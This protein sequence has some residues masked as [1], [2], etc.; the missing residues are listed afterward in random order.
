MKTHLWLSLGVVA[1][2]AACSDGTNTSI[3]QENASPDKDATAPSAPDIATRQF[4]TWLDT[5]FE[6][7]LNFSPQTRTRLGDKTDYDQLDDAS[8]AAERKELEWRRASVAEMKQKFSRDSL[9]AT[10][11]TSWDLWEFLLAQE[12]AGVPYR[13]HRYIFGRRGPHTWL[14][15][16]LI[17]HHKVDT[18]ADLDAY[19][20]RLKQVD[21]Q[22]GQ[23]LDRAKTS[24][25]QG[26][27][28]PYFD[29]ELALSQSQ[30]VIDGEPF[31]DGE[32]TALWL[33]INSKIDSLVAAGQM[34]ETGADEYRT[35]FSTAMLEDVESAY[36]SVIAWLSSDKGKV[37]DEAQGAWALPDGEA[38]YN[39]TLQQMTTLPLTADEIHQTGLDEVARIHAEMN[40]IRETVDFEGTLQEFFVFMREDQQFY[41][42]SNDEGREAYLALAREYLADMEAALPAYFDVLPKAELEVRR[43]ESFREQAGGAAHYVRGTPDGSRPGVFY[44]HLVDMSAQPRYRLENLAYHEGLPGHHM[45]ISIQQEL[46]GVPRF[47]AFHG[48]TAYVEGWALYSELLGKD[49]GFYKDPYSDFGRLSGELWRAIRLV[50]DTGIHAQQWTEQEAIDYA[51]VNSPKAT[52]A[53]TS[54]IRRYFNNPAQATAYKIGMMKILELRGEAQQALGDQFD[55]GEFHT[56]V[57]GG[58]S[59]PLAILENRF[60]RWLSRK[61]A[62]TGT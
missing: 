7:Y 61:Q 56:V 49:M 57:L 53:V 40:E 18:V 35:A 14:P 24:A 41:F 5:E 54:E 17:N 11:K 47:R 30:R 45:Q 44:A 50:V 38:Y 1:L 55:F 60:Q 26:I 13:Y 29:Y 22:L 21:R 25:S 37:S 3:S 34:D 4:N 62:V 39:Y 51:L 43:V 15:N 33:D 31:T 42:P 23:Y 2:L 32:P 46:D 52:S 28:A 48:Y 12:E 6:E 58:G 20:S 16:T 59:L 10:G 36:Q 9:D 8:M 19:L 27:R